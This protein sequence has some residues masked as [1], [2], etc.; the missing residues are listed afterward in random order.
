MCAKGDYSRVYALYR[1]NLFAALFPSSYIF[2]LLGIC[3]GFIVSF[4]T[5]G[6][7]SVGMIFILL[8]IKVLRI[9]PV[10]DLLNSSIEY[11]LPNTCKALR[12]NI[13][14]S[15]PVRVMGSLPK[16]GIYLMHP[17]GLYNISQGLHIGSDFTE[18]PE[19][20]IKGTVLHTLWK[21]PCTHEFLERFVPSNYDDMKKALDT[22]SLSI[23]I[24]GLS[25]TKIQPGKFALKLKDRKGAFKLAIET[26]TPLVPVLVY[27]ENEIFQA[28][29]RYDS[30]IP[31]ILPSVRSIAQTMNLIRKPYDT[32]VSTYVGEPI[33]VQGLGFTVDALRMTYMKKLQELYKDTKPSHYPPEIEFY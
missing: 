30:F 3:I 6:I 2:I 1:M 12:K 16:K 19:R 17:H 8:Y 10:I 24:G 4:V 11:F 27:G 7:V 31:I 9:K 26:G 33:E 29:L 23:S 13:A 20:N 22:Q 21:I 15:F 14:Q 25:E 28:G 5:F 32:R 18:W